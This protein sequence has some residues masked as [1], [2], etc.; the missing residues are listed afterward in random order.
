MRTITSVKLVRPTQLENRAIFWIFRSDQSKIYDEIVESHHVHCIWTPSV[1]AVTQIVMNSW[2]KPS[3]EISSAF[4]VTSREV[5][6]KNYVANLLS[7]QNWA[8]YVAIMK[9]WADF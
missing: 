7:E 9:F 3:F 6:Q 2:R 8:F 4:R 1:L 5:L